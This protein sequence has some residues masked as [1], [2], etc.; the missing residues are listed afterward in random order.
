MKKKWFGQLL[1]SPSFHDPQGPHTA[2]E[3]DGD[4]VPLMTLVR[5]LN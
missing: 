3:A 1:H 5:T 4:Q 2:N